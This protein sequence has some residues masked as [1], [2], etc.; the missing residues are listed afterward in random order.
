MFTNDFSRKSFVYFMKAKSE[1]LDK[2]ELY[3]T[4]VKAKI[5]EKI[6]MLRTNHN[7]EYTSKMFKEYCALLGIL[8]EANPLE[9]MTFPEGVIG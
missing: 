6:L 7:V 1:T 9:Q 8:I 3:T 2:F 5:G 4:Q